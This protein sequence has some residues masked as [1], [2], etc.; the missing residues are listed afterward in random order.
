MRTGE[1]GDSIDLMSCV[2]GSNEAEWPA[3][4]SS[5]APT[6]CAKIVRSP[7]HSQN[8]HPSTNHPPSTGG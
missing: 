8:H 6:G 4:R 5:P 1:S 3:C 2:R 7:S